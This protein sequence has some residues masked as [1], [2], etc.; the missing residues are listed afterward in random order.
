MVEY[1]V[2]TEEVRVRFTEG[3]FILNGVLSTRK[4]VK[5]KHYAIYK[6]YPA[7]GEHEDVQSDRGDSVHGKALIRVGY[8]EVTEEAAERIREGI[9]SRI[10]SRAAL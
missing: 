4:M 2:C 8:Y 3:P 7:G 9:R 6:W 1:L 5:V 10:R